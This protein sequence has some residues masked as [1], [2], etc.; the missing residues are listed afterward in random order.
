MGAGLRRFV[1]KTRTR[2]FDLESTGPDPGACLTIP[3]ASGAAGGGG[4]GNRRRSR[5]GRV[6]EAA[7][8]EDAHGWCGNSLRDATCRAPACVFREPH[9][10]ASL[11]VP[12]RA[13]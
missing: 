2:A 7:G 10:A 1:D 5:P 9:P 4:G 8:T 11:L 3:P 6:V 13:G 12:R